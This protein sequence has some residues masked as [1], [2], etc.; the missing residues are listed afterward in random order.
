MENLFISQLFIMM[1]VTLQ[2]D[3][4]SDTMAF[5]ELKFSFEK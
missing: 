5:A 4:T 2:S 3:V 1:Y